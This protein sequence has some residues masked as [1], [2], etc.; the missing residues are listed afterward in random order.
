MD[1]LLVQY[2]NR[3]M[4]FRKL[5]YSW[6]PLFFYLRNLVVNFRFQFFYF[7]FIFVF[8]LKFLGYRTLRKSYA[9]TWLLL[10]E[11]FVRYLAI[12]LGNSYAV[13]QRVRATFRLLNPLLGENHHFWIRDVC[14]GFKIVLHQSKWTM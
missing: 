5:E 7:T 10:I 3:R 13:F 12:F 2:C 6:V 11:R 4:L 8:Y 1:S 9:C 14:R